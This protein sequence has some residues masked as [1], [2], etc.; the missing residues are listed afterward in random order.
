MI[1]FNGIE[2]WH[3]WVLAILLGAIEIFAPSFFFL[4]LGFAAAAVGILVLVLPNL[5]LEF[6]LLFFGLFSVVSVVIWL[7]FVR[8]RELK[9]SVSKLNQRAAQYEGRTTTLEQAIENGV[10]YVRLDD[11]RWKVIGPDLPRGTKVK[12]TGADG[13]ILQVEQA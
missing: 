3:W 6:Q 8:P 5:G 11:S 13:T 9:G 12:I 7:R 1:E 4:W 10:G 2:F